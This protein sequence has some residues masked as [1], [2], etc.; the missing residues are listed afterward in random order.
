MDEMCASLESLNLRIEELSTN[1]PDMTPEELAAE[2]KVKRTG[3][4]FSFFFSFFF[5]VE[6][7]GRARG[8]TGRVG[9]TEVSKTGV[10]CLAVWLRSLGRKGLN[11][12]F[13]KAAAYIKQKKRER[14]IEESKMDIE[15]DDE[16]QRVVRKKGRGEEEEDGDEEEE[17]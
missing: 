17:G 8:D 1:Y 12:T 4:F 9:G 15:N 5:F 14:E 2:I 13:Q 16:D 3:L 6:T 10:H 11:E 7:K